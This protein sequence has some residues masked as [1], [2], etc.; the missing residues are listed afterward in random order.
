VTQGWVK[1][2]EGELWEVRDG[3]VTGRVVSIPVRIP[4]GR[5]RVFRITY[6]HVKFLN[7]RVLSYLGPAGGGIFWHEDSVVPERGETV[8]YLVGWPFNDVE[9]WWLVLNNPATRD[10][11]AGIYYVVEYAEFDLE[12]FVFGYTQRKQFPVPPAVIGWLEFPEG[13][14]MTFTNHTP[15]GTAVDVVISAFRAGPVYV[16]NTR[17]QVGPNESVKVKIPKGTI[18]TFEVSARAT[19]EGAGYVTVTWKR[20]EV[21]PKPPE[22]EKPKPPEAPSPEKPELPESPWDALKDLLRRVLRDEESVKIDPVIT[23]ALIGVMF[24]VLTYTI[25]QLDGFV[26]LY[27]LIPALLFTEWHRL[28]THLW[29]HASWEH[30]IGNMLFL[31]VFGDNVEERLGYLRYLLFYLGA[32]I[33][34]GLGWVAYAL[35]VPGLAE[36]PAVGASGAISGVM[37]AYAVLFPRAKVVFMG[38]RMPG[39]VFLALWFLSQFAIAFQI[40]AVAWMAHVAGFLFGVVIG[41]AV[42]ALEREVSVVE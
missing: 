42:R 5:G 16:Y 34:A 9:E 25:S 21:P 14:Q 2:D 29:L 22:P 8:H 3:D 39:Q 11:P 30:Y 38:R 4:E 12:G 24:T 19:S 13:G 10:N 15:T 23:K 6:R 17:V 41:Y 40:T 1:L 32:G 37:G 26:A 20:Y 35:A 7:G 33:V 31:Y 27:G 18:G 36:V 28:L